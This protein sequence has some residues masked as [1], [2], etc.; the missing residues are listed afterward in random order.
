MMAFADYYYQKWEKCQGRRG[1][2]ESGEESSEEKGRR[3]PTT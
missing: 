1:Q 3:I 2:K